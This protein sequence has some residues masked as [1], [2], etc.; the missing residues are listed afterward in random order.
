MRNWV[1]LETSVT[2]IIMS[3][4]YFEIG[5]LGAWEIGF[6]INQMIFVVDLVSIV[7][8]EIVSQLKS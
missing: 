4:W 6:K 7:I 2:A 1:K 8:Y 5:W 3:L